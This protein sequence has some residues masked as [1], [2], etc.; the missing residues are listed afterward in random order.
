MSEN[1]NIEIS[2]IL[3]EINNILNNDINLIEKSTIDSIKTQI[4]NLLDKNISNENNIKYI[5]NKI[6]SYITLSN[7]NEHKIGF[8]LLTNIIITN[9]I[10][11]I[12]YYLFDILSILQENISLKN[13]DEIIFNFIKIIEK[14]PFEKN[15]NSFEQ[16]NNFCVNNINDYNN[17]SIGIECYKN[18][19]KFLNFD[20]N[21]N[22]ENLI[23]KKIHLNLQN[24]LEIENFPKINEILNLINDL[25]L[26]SKE[27]FNNYSA[28]TLYKILDFLAS[29]DEK[30]KIISLEIIKNLLYFNKSSII[31][32]KEQIENFIGV[33][34]LNQDENLKEQCLNILIL[35]N[36]D[37]KKNETF[38]KQF[39]DNNN[40]NENNNND[41]NN[42]ENNNN[43]NINNNN[44][45]NNNIENNIN[46]NINNNIENNNNNENNSKEEE[47]YNNNNNNIIEN[48]SNN[49]INL[50]NFNFNEKD[51]LNNSKSENNNNNNKKEEEKIYDSPIKKEDLTSSLNSN[52]KFNNNNN[53]YNNNKIIKQYEKKFSII[54]NKM[55]E[56]S[57]KQLF[58]IDL[59]S[60]IK[61]DSNE[62]LFNLNK[63][64]ENIEKNN[65]NNKNLNDE[66][67]NNNNNNNDINF[68]INKS[69]NSENI[70]DL[71]NEI[72][73]LNLNKICLLN[74]NLIE[75]ILLRIFP[76]LIKGKF[77][78][79]SVIFIK[80]IFINKKNNFKLKEVTLKNLLD[81]FNYI[82][83]NNNINE[84]DLIDIKL[85]ISIL[86]KT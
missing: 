3:T 20:N 12:E 71:I 80:S 52:N 59:I 73:S 75:N 4:K 28:V 77:L 81:V 31:S 74:E 51:I 83:N 56:M 60:N 35:L 23:L 46:N 22:N 19:I 2:T 85:L 76:F 78:H 86:N 8:D 17:I 40:N 58:I 64:I 53:N 5:L 14:I 54:L 9:N 37:V 38:N 36:S 32:L 68:I 18:L 13:S 11:F 63:R 55:K 72:K 67:N 1:N 62:K 70:N 84:E 42:N 69:L 25:I 66:F 34:D 33:I 26:K 82:Q 61:K 57:N 24:F 45:Q 48:I 27:N 43:E 49:S 21:N 30:N 16:I 39:E 6:S 47:N 10:K 41:N 44:I 29:E 7:V 15:L 65:K 79:E 50:E